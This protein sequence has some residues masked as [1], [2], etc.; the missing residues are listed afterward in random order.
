MGMI[1]PRLGTLQPRDQKGRMPSSSWFE[2]EQ[3]FSLLKKEP[4]Q[5]RAERDKV[6]ITPGKAP[7][8]S[9]TRLLTARPRHPRAL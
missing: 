8:A 2:G 6:L 7:A 1:T 4:Q 3:V 9:Q 5:T